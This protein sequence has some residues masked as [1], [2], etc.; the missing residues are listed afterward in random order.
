[1]MTIEEIQVH[2]ES[3]TFECKSIQ[4]DPKA[5]AIPIVAM[6]NAV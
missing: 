6:A 1:M 2:K 5:L 3:Q 4:I